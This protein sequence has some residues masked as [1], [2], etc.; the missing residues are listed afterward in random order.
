MRILVTG[1][2]GYIGSHMVRMLAG[3][4][5]DAVVVDTLEHGYRAALP[6]EVPLVLG[7]V[8]EKNILEEAFAKPID[9]VMH[10]AGYISVEESVH[11]PRKYLVNNLISPCTLLECMEEHGVPAIIFS[12]TAAV[13]GNPIT[14]PIPEDHPKEPTSPYGLSKWCFEELLSCLERKSAVKSISL[15]YFN[16]AGAALDGSYGEAHAP[17]THIIPLAI[18][19]A[20]ETHEF[21]LFGTDYQTRDGSCERDYIHVEDLCA[22]HL[23]TL[24]ALLNGHA[25][26]VYNVGTGK[27]ITNREVMAEVEKLSGKRI[28]LKEVARRSGDAGILVADST[29][30]RKE[31]HWEPKHS[32]ISTIVSSAL[33]WHTTH[34]HGYEDRH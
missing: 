21:A 3:A 26:G 16:A 20:L 25:S 9:A 18:K 22:A 5:L 27:G 12:S 6:S 13:Y 19:A 29:R 8:G 31:F 4:G 32:D 34:P 28:S 30:L 15:R 23:K 17:E 11:N 33:T 2:A 10:F 1:G 7:S 24:D 14:V